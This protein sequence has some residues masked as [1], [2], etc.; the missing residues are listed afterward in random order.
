MEKENLEVF[1][2]RECM[3]EFFGKESVEFVWEEVRLMMQENLDV[4]WE[5]EGMDVF[6]GKESKGL[7][8]VAVDVDVFWSPM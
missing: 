2:Q 6:L 7:V 4:Y 1:W 8:W 3:E 5:R